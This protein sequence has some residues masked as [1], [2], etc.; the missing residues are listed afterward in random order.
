MEELWLDHW[1]MAQKSR[2]PEGWGG[3]IVGASTANKPA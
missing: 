1:H 3:K 2:K